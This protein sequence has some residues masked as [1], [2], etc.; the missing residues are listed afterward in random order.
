MIMRSCSQQRVAEAGA[1]SWH[2]QQ[3]HAPLW[4]AC[5][6]N[7]GPIEVRSFA[8]ARQ[9]V[10]TITSA[11]LGSSTKQVVHEQALGGNQVRQ[12]GRVGGRIEGGRSGSGRGKGE[13]GEGVV[14]RGGVAQH[15][16]LGG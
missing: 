11:V 14:G 1:P 8:W 2:L 16:V 4:P 7:G 6:Q 5:I 15:T 10:A 3:S 12:S 9:S 13:E